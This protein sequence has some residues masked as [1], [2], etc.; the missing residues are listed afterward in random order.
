LEFVAAP[1]L[2]P[3]EVQIDA[4]TLQQVFLLNFYVHYLT[5]SMKMNSKL[6]L[7]NLYL[8]KKMT[9]CKRKTFKEQLTL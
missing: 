3:P 8:L 9:T 2:A 6:L 5:F 4:Q 1:A 7:I